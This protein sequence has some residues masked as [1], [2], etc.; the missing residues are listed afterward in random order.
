[1]L[2]VSFCWFSHCGY[3]MSPIFIRS[4]VTEQVSSQLTLFA[5][6][7]RGRT[8]G[9]FLWSLAGSSACPDL[10]K[11]PLFWE[12]CHTR[13]AP[14]WSERC[15]HTLVLCWRALWQSPF[16]PE[17]FG[18]CL[19]KRASWIPSGIQVC[20]FRSVGCPDTSARAGE[21]LASCTLSCRTEWELLI[22]H[23]YLPACVFKA[24]FWHSW[25]SFSLRY[26]FSLFPTRTRS[27]STAVGWF[28]LQFMSWKWWVL[29]HMGQM[30][31][32]PI[33][34][35]IPVSFLEQYP[36]KA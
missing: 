23:P 31:S 22:H 28:L 14:S 4:E 25:N 11:P 12:C 24:I 33:S 17:P 8:S 26:S 18:P 15:C 1:M 32:S 2:G 34:S 27:G 30:C 35:K 13:G 29:Y 5:F 6:T 3:L 36:K 10:L 7:A 21:V 9:S 20:G 16:Q 19:S